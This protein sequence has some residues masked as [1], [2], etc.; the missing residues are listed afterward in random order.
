[1]SRQSVHFIASFISIAP[2]EMRTSGPVT[3]QSIPGFHQ[4]L[5]DPSFGTRWNG[6]ARFY[7]PGRRTFH[8]WHPPQSQADSIGHLPSYDGGT[9]IL[10]Q[11]NR[12]CLFCWL[13]H[14]A[15]FVDLVGDGSGRHRT[16]HS[17]PAPKLYTG[18][19]R[20]IPGLRDGFFIVGAYQRL[21]PREV[22]VIAHS[23]QAIIRHH[24]GACKPGEVSHSRM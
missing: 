8:T 10:F 17:R 9:A 3:A 7:C 13:R 23:V 20:Q 21:E 6:N 16:Y 19:L 1:M 22:T 5:V 11:A 18:A 4:G 2:G 15:T 14:Q 24:V 12:R